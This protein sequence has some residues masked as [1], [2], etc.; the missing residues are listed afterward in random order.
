MKYR[1]WFLLALSPLL[2][3]VALVG[4][5]SFGG[6]DVAHAQ[7]P[8]LQLDLDQDSGWCND[9]DNTANVQNGATHKA[10]IC[11]T[12]VNT[13]AA[14]SDFNIVVNYTSTLNSCVSKGQ[15]GTALDANPDFISTVG[16][17]W[18][19]SGGGLNYPKCG[20]TAG[21]AFITCGTVND[22]GTY[23]TANSAIAVIEWTA[24]N[25]GADAL[26]WGA[27]AM[28][29]YSGALVVRCPGANCLGSTVTKQGPT[30]T[31]GPATPT[32]TPPPTATNTPWCG[33]LRQTPCPTSTPTP[34]SWTKTPT[35]TLTGT[36]AAPTEPAPPPPP[37][38]PPPPTG[39][40][41]PAVVPPATGTGSGSVDWTISLMWALA[42]AGALSVFLGGLYLRRARNR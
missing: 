1:Q 24:N 19:C 6:P 34:K 35:P 7:A 5:R 38:P 28:Y 8:Q 25:T 20:E 29:D 27:G 39:G 37:P 13:L 23:A 22:P 16:T 11:L 9:I 3:A 33:G 21:Q 30:S 2:F 26:S 36:P 10:A 40:Q 14:V 15:S 18:D 41:L 4:V 32:N 31:P 12:G 17:G 42:G